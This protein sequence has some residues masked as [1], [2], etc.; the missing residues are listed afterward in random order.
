[1]DAGS[2]S[3]SSLGDRSLKAKF[4]AGNGNDIVQR[5]VALPVSTWNYQAQDASIRHLGPMAQDFQAAFGLGED[6]T[7]ISTVDEQGVALA[8]IQGLYATVQEKDAQIASQD[9]RLA[10]L[11]QRQGVAP[12]SVSSDPPLD[13]ALL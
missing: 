5:R 4:A 11:E 13:W 1:L 8:A 12:A 2:R 6:D 7:T 9:A 10:A 3:W